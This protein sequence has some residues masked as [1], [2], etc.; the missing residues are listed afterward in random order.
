MSATLG[1]GKKATRVGR[2]AC[3]SA[4]AVRSGE[5]SASLAAV[6]EPGLSGRRREAR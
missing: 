3:T 5:E 6:S 4:F 2:V 1:G